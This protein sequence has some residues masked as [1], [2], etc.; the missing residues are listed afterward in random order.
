MSAA[1]CRS[2]RLEWHHTPNAGRAP[3][4]LPSGCHNLA[5]LL[6]LSPNTIVEGFSFRSNFTYILKERQI[7][8]WR[9][10]LVGL[11]GQIWFNRVLPVWLRGPWRR[12]M[13]HALVFECRRRLDRT[14]MRANA[15]SARRGLGSSPGQAR[16]DIERRRRQL[17]HIQVLR[18][19]VEL[20]SSARPADVSQGARY[21]RP[22]GS[23][24]GRAASACRGRAVSAAPPPTVAAE[25]V[26]V[27]VRLRLGAR[28]DVGLPGPKVDPL[29]RP[30]GGCLPGSCGIRR[31]A[32]GRRRRVSWRAPQ[33]L[34]IY[35]RR[36]AYPNRLADLEPMFGRSPTCLST[37][38]SSSMQHLLLRGSDASIED[39]HT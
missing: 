11:R 32:A 13:A 38:R 34:L 23:C 35:L 22:S 15:P 31:A 4:R 20:W 14:R 18:A 21:A 28:L 30:R 33:V 37:C 10:N 25:G 19:A 12:E 7:W 2:R 3:R 8:W 17:A 9:S 39:H 1:S 5:Q 6:S 36:I 26:P 16:A 24:P 27:V 29:P